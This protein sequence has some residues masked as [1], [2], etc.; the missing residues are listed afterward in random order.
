[1]LPLIAHLFGDYVFQNS[2]MAT[3]KT[4]RSVPC[5]VHVFCYAAC[6]ALLL[7]PSLAA[8]AL[9]AGTH[10][11]I[12]RFRLARYIIWAVEQAAPSS[13]RSSW[14]RC[15]TTGYAPDTPAWLSTWL[16]IIVDNTLHLAIN[17]VALT[18]L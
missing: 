9:I 10:F 11:L 6:F 18:Y 1:M 4:R 13:Y 3:Q 2:W 7:R 17:Y 15:A 5:I 14:E 8:L 16:L 12:D